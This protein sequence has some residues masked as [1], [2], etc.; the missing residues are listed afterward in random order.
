MDVR[1][2]RR[3]RMGRGRLPRK[4]NVLFIIC[5]DLNNDLGAMGN[6]DVKSPNIH[7][8]PMR[9]FDRAYRQY[10]QCNPSPDLFLSGSGLTARRFKQRR[11]STDR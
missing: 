5:D 6:L 8:G 10:P 7:A 1:V 11:R 4:P 2:R 3:L 9:R